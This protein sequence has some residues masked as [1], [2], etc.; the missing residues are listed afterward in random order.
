MHEILLRVLGIIS[1]H[2]GQHPKCFSHA[3][4]RPKEGRQAPV[5]LGGTNSEKSGAY[6]DKN[7]INDRIC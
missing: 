2:V 7:M 1:R 3:L 4:A 5:G 6:N